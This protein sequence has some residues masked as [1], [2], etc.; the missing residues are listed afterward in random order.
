MLDEPNK[1]TTKM[2]KLV[3]YNF[4]IYLLDSVKLGVCHW[5]VIFFIQLFTCGE[6]KELELEERLN[7]S[8]VKVSLCVG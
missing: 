5:F 3:S 4:I 7:F 8:L 1:Q 6:V 2:F